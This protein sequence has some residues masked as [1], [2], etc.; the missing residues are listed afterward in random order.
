MPRLLSSRGRFE[1][2]NKNLVCWN[3]TPKETGEKLLQ[4][5]IDGQTYTKELSVGDGFK[6][7]S[8]R[9]PPADWNKLCCIPLKHHSAKI[10]W[11]SRL[12]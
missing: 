5:E 9:R 10:R 8:L 6:L 12:M 7:T 2:R 4:F 1:F 11:F 3:L